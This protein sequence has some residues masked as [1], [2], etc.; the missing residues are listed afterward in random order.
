M[1]GYCNISDHQRRVDEIQSQA[2]RDEVRERLFKP[3]PVESLPLAK[4][5][6]L[7][8]TRLSEEL[9]YVRRL[10][11]GVGD[12]LVADPIVLQK[13]AVTLQSFDVISQL[14]GHLSE[15][16]A[17]ADRAAAIGRIGMH[18]LKTRLQRPVP[19]ALAPAP[20][21]LGRRRVVPFARP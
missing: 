14:I 13:H 4:T 5:D 19:V 2:R 21:S 12:R 10:L 9:D 16:I 15:V 20:H 8:S 3:R 17:T 6:D 7:I 18:E 1:T 11:E